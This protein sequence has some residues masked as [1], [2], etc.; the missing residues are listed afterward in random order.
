MII[1]FLHVQTIEYYPELMSTVDAVYTG[2]CKNRDK[3]KDIRTPCLSA[4]IQKSINSDP[5]KWS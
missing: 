1:H 5:S 4:A 3:N 2:M